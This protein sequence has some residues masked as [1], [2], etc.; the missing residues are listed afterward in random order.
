M[1]VSGA[2]VPLT[3]LILQRGSEQDRG[4]RWIGGRKATYAGDVCKSQ[5][6]CSNSPA[7]TAQHHQYRSQHRSQANLIDTMEK[8][9]GCSSCLNPLPSRTIELFGCR[10]AAVALTTGQSDDSFNS[11]TP[12]DGKQCSSQ[13]FVNRNRDVLALGM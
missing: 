8:V 10:A 3:F 12:Y 1:F 9:M 4:R 5:A 6:D 11:A 7:S 2:A 13:A